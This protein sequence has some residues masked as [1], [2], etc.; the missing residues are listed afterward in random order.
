MDSILSEESRCKRET[1]VPGLGG[2]LFA[3]NR[4]SEGT[5]GKSGGK[6]HNV[7][8]ARVIGIDDAKVTY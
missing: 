1:F 6:T 2:V 8:Y 4:K 5:C 3:K 7:Q